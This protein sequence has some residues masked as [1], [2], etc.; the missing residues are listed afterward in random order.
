M[1]KLEEL[2][3]EY[4]LKRKMY[5]EQEEDLFNQRNQ[6]VAVIDEVQERSN[7]YL[8]KS[9]TDN[10]LLTQGFRETE[11]MKEEILE[12][13]KTKQ[14]EISREIEELDGDYYRKRRL[15]DEE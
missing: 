6:A 12:L 9:I 7:Y 4:R 5:E 8:K 14:R 1:D 3:V 13:T 10:D 2:E 15:L 11:Q